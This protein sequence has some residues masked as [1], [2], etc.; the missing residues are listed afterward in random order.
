MLISI[1]DANLCA[2][3]PP[4]I[5]NNSSSVGLNNRNVNIRLIMFFLSITHIGL[6][7]SVTQISS[8][9]IRTDSSLFP[10]RIEALRT[11][12]NNSVFFPFQI[13]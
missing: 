10:V 11:K 2:V 6:E 7:I 8:F 3:R 9:S 12:E 13:R 5:F 1:I 4:Q